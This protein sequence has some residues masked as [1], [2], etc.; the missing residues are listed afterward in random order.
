MT[1]AEVANNFPGEH[2]GEHAKY[3]SWVRGKVPLSTECQAAVPVGNQ[4]RTHK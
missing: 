2:L 3:G 4:T 1:G